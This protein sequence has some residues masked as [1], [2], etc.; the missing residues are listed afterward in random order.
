MNK[1]RNY[2]CRPIRTYVKVTSL[3]QWKNVSVVFSA[4]GLFMLY[5]DVR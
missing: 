1:S 4:E 3:K 2:Y 5:S